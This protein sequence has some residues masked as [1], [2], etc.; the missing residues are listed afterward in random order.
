MDGDLGI[1]PGGSII[2]G[3]FDAPLS[4]ID[5]PSRQEIQSRQLN[6]TAPIK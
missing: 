5:K 1:S 2:G 3:D 6:E 4:V